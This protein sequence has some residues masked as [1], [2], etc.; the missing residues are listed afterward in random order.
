MWNPK[1]IIAI[2]FDWDGVITKRGEILKQEAWD[3]L[4]KKESAEFK[5]ALAEKRYAFSGGGGSRYDILRHTFTELGYPKAKIE[6]MVKEYVR[7]YQYNVL[8]LMSSDIRPEVVAVL[9]NLNARFAL[10][11]NSATA[12]DGLRESAKKVGLSE[13]F[14][15]IY[16]FSSDN[17]RKSKVDNLKQILS[18]HYLNH[19][20]PLFG[21]YL[22]TAFRCL[23]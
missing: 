23:C 20:V 17:R 1:N 11:V 14:K 21:H 15:N 10:Y 22:L 7:R 18:A 5:E 19:L 12:E 6:E 3:I 16:G 9:K 4:A 8:N 13:F 2:S